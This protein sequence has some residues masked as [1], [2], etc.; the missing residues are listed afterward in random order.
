MTEMVSGSFS[1]A[2]SSRSPFTLSLNSGFSMRWRAWRRLE[3]QL[4][5]GV[6]TVSAPCLA[7]R[8]RLRVQRAADSSVLTAWAG[9]EPQQFQSL[10]SSA[11]IPRTLQTA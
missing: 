3:R 5:Q 1:G 2:G 4:G 8:E 9:V 11:W 10:I 6:T 7:A